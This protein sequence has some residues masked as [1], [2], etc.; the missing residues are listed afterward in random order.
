VTEYSVYLR[1]PFAE[2]RYVS[3]NGSKS[4]LK[5]NYENYMNTIDPGAG[6]VGKYPALRFT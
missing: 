6:Y 3:D 4:V 5:K 1:L 2:F